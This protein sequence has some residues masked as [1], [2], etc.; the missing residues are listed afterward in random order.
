MLTLKRLAVYL[1]TFLLVVITVIALVDWKWLD[2]WL[3][4]EVNSISHQDDFLNKEIV[5]INL[6]KKET[7]S[8]GESFKQFR[9]HIIKLL[10]TVAIEAKAKNGPKGV[11]LDIW[12]SKDTTELENLKVALKQLKDLHVPVYASYNINE[13]HEYTQLDKIDFDDIEDKHAVEVYNEYLAGSDGKKPANG[14]Y[15]TFFYPEKNVA[16]YENDIYFSST[17]FGDSVLIESLASKVYND[18]TDTKPVPKRIGSVVPIGSLDEIAGKTYDFIPDSV[19]STGTFQSANNA[20]AAID[21]DKNIL[22]VGDAQND[23]INFGDKKIPGPYI[24]TWALNDLLNNNSN[25]KLPI[26]NLYVIIGQILFFSFFTVMVFV[27]LFKYIRSLQTKPLTLA[28]LSFVAGIIFFLIYGKL[29]LSFNYVIPAGHTIVAMIVATFLSWRF[30]HKFLVT[31]VADGSEKY[32][33]F[34]SYSRNQS[35]WVDKNVYQPLEAFRKP[36]GEKLTIFYDKKSIG[37]G[38]A[39][40]S[41]YMYAIVNSKTFLAIMSDEYYGKNHCRNEFDCAAKRKVEKKIKFLMVAF[42]DKAVPE[43]YALWNYMNKDSAFIKT[44][45]SEILTPI[46]QVNSF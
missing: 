35:D 5:F 23:V 2:K 1:I 33:V 18:L 13:A 9:Q 38:E 39:F 4:N 3:V 27:L 14:R 17:I 24:V 8:E 11:V 20:N 31:G 21:M 26:E 42:S 37:V 6:E 46:D 30:A 34:I 41:K 44:V 10:N 28:I 19:Q 25:V 7:G 29:I 12:F 36:N 16:N 22:I 40:T 43:S 45:E 15:H 32:D